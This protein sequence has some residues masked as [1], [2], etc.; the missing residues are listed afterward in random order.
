MGSGRG[1]TGRQLPSLKCHN[2][3]IPDADLICHEELETNTPEPHLSPST[4]GKNQRLLHS[5]FFSVSL[6]WSGFIWDT[7]LQTGSSS[8][9]EDVHVQ[10]HVSG[11]ASKHSRLDVSQKG[12]DTGFAFVLQQKIH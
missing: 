11:P 12:R 9:V 2:D 8:L 3:L 5:F 6:I 7:S 1:P 10:T 4:H